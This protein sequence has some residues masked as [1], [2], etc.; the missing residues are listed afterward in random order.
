MT[1]V[2]ALADERAVGNLRGWLSSPIP[3]DQTFFLTDSHTSMFGNPTFQNNLL[4]LLLDRPPD[5]DVGI[6]GEQFESK[7]VSV[8]ELMLLCFRGSQ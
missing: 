6:F 2:S 1:R 4:H 3:W 5:G 7:L 8:L